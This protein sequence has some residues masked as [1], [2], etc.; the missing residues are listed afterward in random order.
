VK[1][2]VFRNRTRKRVLDE[3]A[4]LGLIYIRNL[5]PTTTTNE[6]RHKLSLPPHFY[7]TVSKYYKRGNKNKQAHNL[8]TEQLEKTTIMA[9]TTNSDDHQADNVPDLHAGF[10]DARGED[11]DEEDILALDGGGEDDEEDEDDVPPALVDP[12]VVN[13]PRPRKFLNIGA[14]LQTKVN[15]ELK[16]RFAFYGIPTVG[17]DFRWECRLH[18]LG[19]FRTP[20]DKTNARYESILSQ[21]YRFLAE[22]GEWD[23]M[24]LLCFP[25]KTEESKKCPA[26][27]LEAICNFM[28]YKTNIAGTPLKDGNNEDCNP[29]MHVLNAAPI[30][31]NKWTWTCPKSLEIAG[32]AISLIHKLHDHGGSYIECCE[33]CACLHE[34]SKGYLVSPTHI[35]ISTVYTLCTT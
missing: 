11:D 3:P 33:E 16:K 9:P 18:R 32:S 7:V 26:M 28:R 6:S 31:S 27:R 1:K 22:T 8:K 14:T 2:G 20:N 19:D 15:E 5:N 24:M 17:F 4:V 21:L 30:F 35:R 29:V 12:A 34:T 25:R 23:S 13:A 10:E